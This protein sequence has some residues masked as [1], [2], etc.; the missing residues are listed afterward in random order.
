MK[1]CVTR[2]RLRFADGVVILAE[3]DGARVEVEDDRNLVAFPVSDAKPSGRRPAAHGVKLAER[4]VFVADE[5]TRLRARRL[6]DGDDAEADV[7]VDLVD[8]ERALVHA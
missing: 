8:T 6:G 4:V 7:L 1:R 3:T 2:Y 5:V